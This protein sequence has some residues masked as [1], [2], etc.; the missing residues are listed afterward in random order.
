M[1][2]ELCFYENTYENLAASD[3]DLL[4][5]GAAGGAVSTGAGCLGDE[6]IG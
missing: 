1:K 2:K 3:G 5:C 4:E 6:V